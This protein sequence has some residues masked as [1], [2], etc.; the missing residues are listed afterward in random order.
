MPLPAPRTWTDGE[1]PENIP[2][3]DDL[4]LDWRDSFN[5]LMGST[6]PMGLFRTTTGQALSSTFVNINLPLEVLKRGGITHSTVTNTHLITVPY[7]GQYQ[8]YASASFD[9]LSAV[10]LRLTLRLMKN[11]STEIARFNMTN[12]HSNN[13]TVN[14]TFTADLAA[15]DTI[16]MQLGMSSG[17]STSGAAVGRAPRIGIWYAG[18]F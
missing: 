9:T 2:N 3:A 1:Q 13:W 15:N 11:T 4:N 14:G 17:T 16:H 8:G 18:D 7:A 12:P 5:F 6:R 10:G